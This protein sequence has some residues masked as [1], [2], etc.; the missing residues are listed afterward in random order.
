MLFSFHSAQQFNEKMNVMITM[1]IMMI[2]I[3]RFK[4]IICTVQSFRQAPFMG[5][6]KYFLNDTVGEMLEPILLV[7][8]VEPNL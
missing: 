8:P 1:I 3:L 5:F 4:Q 2:M 7:H 6:Y